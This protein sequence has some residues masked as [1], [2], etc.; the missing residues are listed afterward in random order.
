MSRTAGTVPESLPA[1]RR[2]ELGALLRAT[3]GLA[4]R[5]TALRL[6]LAS[7]APSRYDG[8]VGPALRRLRAGIGT[9]ADVIIRTF[10][11]GGPGGL[12]AIAVFVDGLADNQMIDQDLLALAESPPD[13]ARV[14]AGKARATTL[15]ERV[16]V[17]HVSYA[18]PWST[19]LAKALAGNTVVLVEGADRALVLD[20]VKYPARSIPKPDM[21][22]SVLG[23]HEGFNEI[24]L[25]HMNQLRRYLQTPRLRFESRTFGSLTGTQAVIVWVDGVTNPAIVQAVRRRLAGMRDATVVSVSRLGSTLRD[26][27]WTP[28]PL[29]RQT[30]RVDFVAREVAQGRVAVLTAN[31]PF[32]ILVPATFVDFYQTSEDYEGQFWGPTLDR[33]VRLIAF[34]VAVYAPALYIGLSEV[35]PDFMPTELLWTVA[36]SRENLPFSPQVE[37]ILMFGV[38][39]ILREAALRMPSAMSTALSTVGA[40]IIGTPVVHLTCPPLGSSRFRVGMRVRGRRPAA[41]FVGP[42]ANRRR[43]GCGRRDGGARP[44]C[45]LETGATVRYGGRRIRGA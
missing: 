45:A 23:S 9:S 22:R 20:T 39:E 13:A 30:P 41:L 37:V 12:G 17:G 24:L 28:F 19:I 44:G 3:K 18:R 6:R 8:R 5:L 16:S 32:A 15:A 2:A 31:S 25:T 43:C 26:H 40:V 34:F 33:I 7:A 35:N 36:G 42:S 1:D 38:F 14:P 29:V 4:L 27:S 11:V 21:E 10:R